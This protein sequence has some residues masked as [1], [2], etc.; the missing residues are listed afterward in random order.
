MP[1]N[2]RANIET[3]AQILIAIAVLVIAGV[4]VKRYLFPARV[5]TENIQEQ[6]QRL[7]GRRIDVPNVDWEQNRKT[8]ILFL[9]KDCSFCKETAPFYRGLIASAPQGNVKWLAILPDSVE[10]GTAYVRSL[11]LPIEHI[12]SA[13]LST[14]KIPGAPVALFVDGKGT[15]KRAWFGAVH[16]RQAQIRQEFIA[17]SGESP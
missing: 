11:D 13:P 8:V 4:V 3:G 7:V 2:V 10:E 14:Y 9:K 6:E 16:D 12:Q 5:I 1:K 17:L 15:I